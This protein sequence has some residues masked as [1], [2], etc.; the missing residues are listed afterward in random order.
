MRCEKRDLN[1]HA[2]Q[3]QNL[4][5]VRLPFRH[6]RISAQNQKRQAPEPAGSCDRYRLRLRVRS[7][8][9]G[10]PPE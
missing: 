1:P 5:L 6:S 2:L 9:G 3:R 10:V 8:R 4:N 7:R